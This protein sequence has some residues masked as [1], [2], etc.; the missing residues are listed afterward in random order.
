MDSTRMRWGETGPRL[1]TSVLGDRMAREAQRKELFFPIHYSE[2]WK[3]FDPEHFAACEKLC[4]EAFTLHLWNSI[5]EKFGFWKNLLPPEGSFLHHLFTADG[6]AA[7]FAATF[8]SANMRQLISNWQSRQTGSS[9]GFGGVI[10]QMLPSIRRT[11]NHYR[12]TARDVSPAPSSRR[13]L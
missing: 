5:V 12:H 4:K 7:C 13:R 3:M 6:S 2:F 11:L 1:L 9:L 10:R 8:P